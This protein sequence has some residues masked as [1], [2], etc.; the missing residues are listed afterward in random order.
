M[1]ALTRTAASVATRVAT[2]ASRLSRTEA[3]SSLR[4]PSR[5][6]AAPSFSARALLCTSSSTEPAVAAATELPR[7]RRDADQQDVLWQ[8]RHI[9]DELPE[10][11]RQAFG[12]QNMSKP[13]LFQLDMHEQIRRWQRTQR[14][15][16][17][18]E[19][20]IA[21]FTER[22]R[23]LSEHMG[24]NH[25]DKKT[26]RQLQLVIN[27]RNSMLKYLRREDRVKYYAVIAGLGLR[28]S[29]AFDPTVRPKMGKAAWGARSTW[30]YVRKKRKPRALAYGAL[31]R[32]CTARASAAVAGAAA[33][34]L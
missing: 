32:C 28:L 26:K 11:V 8:L 22:I 6:A 29:K 17:S 3:S 15:T 5:G 20:Q 18:S 24:A 23:R 12:R 10:S 25:K 13:E 16:G 34:C 27:Q 31:R 7:P 30:K 4:L 21:A 2:S 33:H 14:D 1:L 19:V 9:A